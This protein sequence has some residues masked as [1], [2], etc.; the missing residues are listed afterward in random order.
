MKTLNPYY[1][2]CFLCCMLLSQ[3][4][5]KTWSPPVIVPDPTSSVD[6]PLFLWIGM[7]MLLSYGLGGVFRGGALVYLQKY[8]LL[9][10]L[11]IIPLK[12]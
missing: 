2:I 3:A 1:L 10:F 4:W 9:D 12:R 7:A 6:I 11:L 5:G 8:L